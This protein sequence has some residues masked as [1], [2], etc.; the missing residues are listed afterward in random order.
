MRWG[1]GR[2][3]RVRADR[4]RLRR[5]HGGRSEGGADDYIAKPFSLDALLARIWLRLRQR[6]T[7]SEPGAA[8]GL[9][10]GD[11]SVDIRVRAAT[12]AG[13]TV[14]LSAR[15]F[16]LL[17]MFLSHPGHVLAPA[18]ILSG[19]WATTTTLG[20]TSSRS[21]SANS[22]ASSVTTSSR[23]YEAWATGFAGDLCAP[24]CR[25]TSPVATRSRPRTSSCARRGAPV[26][27]A[28]SASAPS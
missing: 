24:R 23:R 19:V 21:T 17:E 6:S 11:V 20:S 27:R 9:T 26:A 1:R 7:V 10:A 16:S 18:Q 22:A 5:R 4:P 14:E 12:R 25:P 15:E 2:L 28:G 8:M 3:A 13:R